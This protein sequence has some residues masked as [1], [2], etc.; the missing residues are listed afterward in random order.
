MTI[1]IGPYKPLL[2]KVG[3]L[4]KNVKYVKYLTFKF[5]KFSEILYLIL[6]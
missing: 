6:R 2:N 3:A 1:D 5:S 4:N